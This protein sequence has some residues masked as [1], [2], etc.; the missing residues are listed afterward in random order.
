MILRKKEIFGRTLS[1]LLIDLE[2][3]TQQKT[4][5]VYPGYAS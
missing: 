3:D 2:L 1:A 5:E 4:V